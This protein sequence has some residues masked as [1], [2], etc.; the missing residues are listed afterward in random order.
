[1]R[2]AVVGSGVSGLAATWL[3]NEHSDHDVHIYESDSRAG[4]HA[5]TVKVE[6]PDKEPADVDSGFIVFNPTSYPNFLRFLH[7]HPAIEI[8]PTK[9]TFSV[10][11]D[12][13]AFEWAGKNLSTIFCHP[14]RLL[15]PAMWRLLYDVLRFNVCC[16]RLLV[17]TDNNVELS[18]GEYLEREGYSQSFIDNYLIYVQPMTAAVW[19]TPPDVCAL[20]FPARTLIRF[21]HNHHLLQITGKP[22]WLTIKGGSMK[23][24]NAIIS[25]LPENA[26]RLSSSVVSVTSTPYPDA[27]DRFL[28][29]LQTLSGLTENYDHVIFACHSDDTLK[30][31]SAVYAAQQISMVV[32]ELLDDIRTY[33]MNELQHLSLE[34]HGPLFATLNPPTPPSPSKISSIHQYSHPVL[35]ARAVRLQSDILAIQGTRGISY[36]GAWLKYGFHEDGFASGLRA[37]EPLL[38]R[39]G[40][41]GLAFEIAD[42][43]REGAEEI[44]WIAG[45]FDWLERSGAKERIALALGALLGLIRMVLSVIFDL[46]DVKGEA[47]VEAPVNGKTVKGDVKPFRFSGT[48]DVM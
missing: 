16:R 22:S 39:D 41:E 6:S 20:D 45:V 2:I 37:A 40:Q 15:D 9:M 48:R 18:I 34:V 8:L 21:M 1:M 29:T 42:A 4:G 32:L 36:A 44:A 5:N 35:D 43:N 30:I 17:D 11:R 46:R 24:V 3:L 27:D 38:R 13:G 31:M 12:G 14:R 47:R 25:S 26:L 19:S 10:S 33:W 23:Y 28:L 7:S